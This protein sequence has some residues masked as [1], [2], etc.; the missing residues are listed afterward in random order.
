M[1]HERGGV[2][3]APCWRPAVLHHHYY[4]PPPSNQQP[5]P[6]T[7]QPSPATV[8]TQSELELFK[9]LLPSIQNKHTDSTCISRSN[10]T[11]PHATNVLESNTYKVCSKRHKVFLKS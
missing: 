1:A 3:S 6:A 8:A 9:Y 5:S 11:Y 4:T 2:A 7:K 10:I